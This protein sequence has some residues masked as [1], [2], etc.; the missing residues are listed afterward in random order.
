MEFTKK[1]LAELKSSLSH[2]DVM[3]ICQIRARL[4]KNHK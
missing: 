1:D 3:K 2:E 4:R